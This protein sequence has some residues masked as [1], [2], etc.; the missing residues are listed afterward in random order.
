[1]PMLTT[2]LLLFTT[3]PAPATQLDGYYALETTINGSPAQMGVRITHPGGK[4]LV[5]V[6]PAMGGGPIAASATL[7]GN[8]LR[9]TA[10]VHEGADI[11][12][13]LEFDGDN[14]KGTWRLADGAGLIVG[15]KTRDPSSGQ[16]T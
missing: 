5:E 14:V 1:M 9:A 12:L 7:E 3:T 11:V 15:K 10:S 4:L 8:R 13:D 16:A 2:L 6:F